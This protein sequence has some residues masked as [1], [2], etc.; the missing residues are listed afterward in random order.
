MRRIAVRPAMVAPWFLVV[1]FGCGEGQ[2]PLQQYG[3]EVIGAKGRVERVRAEADLKVLETAIQEYYMEHGRFPAS[4]TDV[5]LVQRQRLDPT[6]Y[7][8]DAA[9][10]GIALR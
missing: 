8:Y 2:N 1:V 10:G 7:V 9:T 6:L 5:P 4:L 3:E